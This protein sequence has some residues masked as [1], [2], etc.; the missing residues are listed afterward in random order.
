MVVTDGGPPFNS[1]ELIDFCE[2]HKIKVM[3]SPPYNPSSNGQAERMVRVVKDGLKKFLLDPD[4]QSL[5]CLLLSF[6]LLVWLQKL[7]F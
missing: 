5:P 1:K 6:I 4:L 7:L 3:K 2:K